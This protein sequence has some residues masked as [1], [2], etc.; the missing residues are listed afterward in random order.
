[1]T[2]NVKRKKSDD[3]ENYSDHEIWSA[4]RYLDRNIE[5]QQSGVAAGV[6]WIVVLLLI[7]VLIYLLPH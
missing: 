6:A 2:R 5:P 4:I 7:F 1:M 3:N